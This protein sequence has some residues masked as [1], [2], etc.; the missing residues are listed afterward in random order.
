MEYLHCFFLLYTHDSNSLGLLPGF[1]CHEFTIFHFRQKK[2]TFSSVTPF[3]YWHLLF[4]GWYAAEERASS[5]WLWPGSQTPRDGGSTAKHRDIAWAPSRY[6]K[7]LSAAISSDLICV[8]YT[9]SSAD[10]SFMSFCFVLFYLRNALAYGSGVFIWNWGGW[11][12]VGGQ[13]VEL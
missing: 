2:H 12:E 5:G 3:S 9:M 4:I 10:C 8:G 1:C 11:K 6:L 13:V 7:V